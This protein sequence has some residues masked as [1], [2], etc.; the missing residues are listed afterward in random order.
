MF[1]DIVGYSALA[2]ADEAG[3][4]VALEQ[5]NAILRPLF[6]EHHGREV[7]TVGDAFLVEFGSALD[8][9]RCALAI[10]ARFHR[11]LAEPGAGPKLRLR[12]GLH[13]GDVVESG[14]DL[15]GD[16]VNLASRV[17]EVAEPEGICFTQQVFDQ[18]QNKL[19]AASVRLPPATLKNIRGPVT[20]YR[21]VPP[22]EAPDAP[23]APR[24]GTPRNLA[25][26]PLANISPDPGDEYFAD[27]LTEELISVL[28]GVRGLSVIARTSVAPYK[29]APKPIPQVGAEL[30]VNTVLE[31]SVRKAGKR[32]RITLQLIDVPTQSHIWA[33]RYDRE[34]DDVFAVQTDIAERT[35]RALR[36]ELTREERPAVRR[37]PTSSLEAYDQYLRGLVAVRDHEKDRL[38]EATKAFQRATELDPEFAEAFAAWGNSYV[39]AAGDSL[40]VREA[41][42]RARELAARA[43]ELDPNGSEAHATLGNIHLQFDHDWPRAEAEFLRAIEL[44]PSNVTAHR[45]L[46]LLYIALERFDEAKE[47]IR[48]TIQL[49]PGGSRAPMLSWVEI[50]SGNVDRALVASEETAHRHPNSLWSHQALAFGYL[51]LGRVEE[52]AREAETAIPPADNDERFDRALLLALVGR[53]ESAR[54]Y[55]AELARGEVSDYVSLGYRA[56]LH[57]AVGETDRA[58]TDLEEDLRSG[59]G[60][61][62]LHYRGVFFDPIREE[63]RFRALL[64]AYHLPDHPMRRPLLRVARRP[65]PE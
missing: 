11:D 34:L 1:T 5:H 26:L 12:I 59:D 51:T 40:P 32:M 16:A 58:L 22:W 18:L 47:L 42:P 43:L 31:G 21:F 2:Q 14:G 39:F 57:A 64:R 61:L 6:A 30:G 62:W 23:R 52:A 29:T 41:M 20:L 35:A 65:G 53:P 24:A 44:N 19:P 33:E 63:P 45:F 28:S 25:V 7:K 56:M 49:D 60:L 27:G 8:A 38:G 55:L 3:A 48:R 54:S 46:S 15:L 36:I 10:Q 9:A 4:L 17:H 13:V 50:E 37:P